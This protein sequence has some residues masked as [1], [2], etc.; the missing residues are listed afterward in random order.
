MPRSS[1]DPGAIAIVGISCRLPGAV[2]PAA[3]WRLLAQGE[4]A[5]DEIPAERYRLAGTAQNEGA[6]ENPG[7]RFG[8]FID[9]VDCFERLFLWNLA[10]RGRF[11]GPAAE[12]GARARLG[13]D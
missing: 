2:D 5:V 11:H 13:G 1:R 9:E 6:V 3:L 10:P 8:A 4:E 12:A 7:M